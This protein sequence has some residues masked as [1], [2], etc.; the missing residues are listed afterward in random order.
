MIPE[1][2]IILLNE[3]KK[4]LD[5]IEQTKIYKSSVIFVLY[6]KAYGTHDTTSTCIS[7]LRNRVNKLKKFYEENK[8]KL[9]PIEQDNVKDDEKDNEKVEK[10]T[11]IVENLDAV[12][13]T[14]SNFEG[15]ITDA[16]ILHKE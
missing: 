8:Y 5:D 3:I 16:V 13:L 1:K 4:L 7:C 14:S 9:T 12:I 2:E 15:V 10:P 6:N 11:P